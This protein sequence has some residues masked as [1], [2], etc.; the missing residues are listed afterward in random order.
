MKI[1]HKTLIALLMSALTMGLT[2]P[3]FSKDKRTR[4]EV[5][6]NDVPAAVQAT[7][8]ANAAGGKVIAIEKET[9]RG[10]VTYEAEVKRSDGKMLGIEVNAAGKLISIEVEEK[11]EEEKD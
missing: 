4:E 2:T 7:I 6:W 10:T 8:Q 5:L 1:I 3:G 11:N 9:R